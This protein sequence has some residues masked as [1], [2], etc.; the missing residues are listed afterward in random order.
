MPRGQDDIHGRFLLLQN[1][2]FHHP[3][4]SDVQVPRKVWMR[5]AADQDDCMETCMEAL[6]LRAQD[7]Q[8][9]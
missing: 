5:R 4:W 1:L 9:Q 3:W 6:I 2:H 8:E 7:A